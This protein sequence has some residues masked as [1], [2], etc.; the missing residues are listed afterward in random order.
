MPGRS[1]ETRPLQRIVIT[2]VFISFPAMFVVSALD[3]RFGWSPVPG[4]GLGGRRHPGRGR[5]RH[6]HAG[7]HPKRL[8]GSQH[9]RR[10][11]PEARLHRPVRAGAAPDVHRKRHHDA[12]R[13]AGARLVLGTCLRH[14]R[15]WSVLA[16][17]IRDEEELLEQEF[18]GYRGLHPQVHYRLVP[19]VW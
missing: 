4:H 18:S 3:H 17:R 13:P 15:R 5:T 12:R 14:P 1:A 7:D 11:G 16:L 19:Y 9:H 10:V 6:G 2:V 8:C